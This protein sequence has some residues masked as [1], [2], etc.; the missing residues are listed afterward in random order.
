MSSVD[1]HY[2]HKIRISNI[3]LTDIPEGIYT[4]TS[5]RSHVILYFSKGFENQLSEITF[6]STVSYMLL[7]T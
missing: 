4:A 3:N 2:Y 5:S 7:T 6:Y 1:H